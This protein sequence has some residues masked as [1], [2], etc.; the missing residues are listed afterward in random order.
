MLY[1]PSLPKRGLWAYYEVLGAMRCERSEEPMVISGVPA[2]VEYF[3]WGWSTPLGCWSSARKR[4]P[5]LTSQCTTP[6]LC[7][8]H[9]AITSDL[10]KLERVCPRPRGR[11]IG[12][13]KCVHHALNKFTMLV[14]SWLSSWS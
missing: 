2:S 5:P 1:Y 11:K 8:W 3:R 7:Q 9:K 13:K 12:P 6:C 4:G 14:Q 10:A